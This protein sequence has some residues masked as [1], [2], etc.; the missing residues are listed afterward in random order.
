MGFVSKVVSPFV[1][2]A[3]LFIA[4]S[5]VY[6]NEEPVNL[7][8]SCAPFGSIAYVF[9]NALEDLSNKHSSKVK[10]SSSEGPGTTAITMNLAEDSAW[11]DRV[12]CTSLLDFTYA[13]LGIEPFFPEPNPEIS[14]NVKILFNY[15]YGAIGLLTR[16]DAVENFDDLSGSTIGLGR[17]AQAH[18]GGVPRVVFEKGAPELNVK[19]NYVGSA[20]AHDALADGKFRTISSQVVIS[21]DGETVILPGVVS[22][23]LSQ[24]DDVRML[25]FN[26]E[27]FTKL[28]EVGAPF[29]AIEV[30]SD[31]LPGVIPSDETFNWVFSTVGV[32]VSKD[33]SE[34]LAYE[35]TKMIL[36]HADELPEYNAMFET[37][38]T[39]E[40]LLGDW[41]KE[42]LH[43]GALKAYQEFGLLAD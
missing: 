24:R 19:L 3:A 34:D 6:A 8:F 10:I 30:N 1:A 5:T 29:K 32:A 25:G 9:G 12:G 23:L 16:D 18:W 35:I 22:Q 41:N 43:P 42:D 17:Q 15:L 37:L 39:P 11:V 31:M 33:F 4:S 2:G 20:Q 13:D 36:T 38:D 27:I 28:H 26:E 14:E 21:P 40:K 7:T